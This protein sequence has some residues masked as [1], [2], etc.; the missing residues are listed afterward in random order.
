MK[1]NWNDVQFWI[2]FAVILLF[3]G[4]LIGSGGFW[5]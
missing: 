4:Y 3:I 5:K 2:A 1:V